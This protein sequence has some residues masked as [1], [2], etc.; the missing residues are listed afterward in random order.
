VLL[1]QQVEYVAHAIRLCN[2]FGIAGLA[3]GDAD[4]VRIL[5]IRHSML[6]IARAASPES[7]PCVL[8]TFE[9]LDS[10]CHGRPIVRVTTS[11]VG[12]MQGF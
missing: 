5:L 1:A 6:C 10:T 7:R 8:K 9:T 4:A 11:V 12:A 3:R 2:V